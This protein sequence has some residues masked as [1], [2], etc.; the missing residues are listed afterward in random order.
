MDIATYLQCFESSISSYTGDDPLDQ[1]DK[2]AEYM[3][4]RL[5]ADG[6]KG[7]L[8]VFNRIV[9][10]FLDMERYANDVR[11]VNY[12][13]KCASSYQDPIALFSHVFSKGVGTRTAAFY[14]A[15]AQ[16]FEQ[17]SMNEQADV[18]YQKALENQA[19]PTDAV[20]HHYRQFQARTRI[21]NQTA[22]GGRTPLQNSH[23]TNQMTAQTE[24]APQTNIWTSIDCPPKPAAYKTTITV[25]RSETSGTIPSSFGVPTVAA[26]NKDELEC[27]GSELCFEEVRAQRYFHKLQEKQ[28]EERRRKTEEKLRK[29]EEDVLKVKSMLEEVNRKLEARGAF[30]IHDTAQ[31][32]DRPSVTETA[33]GGNLNL[34]HQALGCPQ[35]WTRPSS[36]R[37]L[38]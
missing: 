22:S 13:I 20:L 12:C 27:E 9:E 32:S 26:Y 34:T 2:F 7:M 31:T 25:S 4:Q 21:Q 6:A 3:E 23:L 33:P 24:P 37:S 35:S 14:M 19:Q 10:K 8:L 16:Q 28:E 38:G 18:V 30:P 29:E 17:K 36:R 1:W 11:Y 15:W 5:P